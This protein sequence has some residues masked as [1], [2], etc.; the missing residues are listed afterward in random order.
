MSPSAVSLERRAAVVVRAPAR[1]HLGFLDPSGSLGRRYGS[2]GL[3]IDGL[4]TVVQVGAAAR[5]ELSVEAGAEPAEL[6]R[7]AGHLDRLR[8]RSGRHAPLA[9]R[10]L[11]TMP[12]H[13]GFGSGTQLALAVG[14][15]FARWHGLP[16][17]APVLAAWLGRG[18]RSGVG[19][20]G[21]GHGGLLIDGGPGHD[22][23]VAPLL[24]RVDLPASWRVVLVLDPRRQGLSGGAEK[25]AIGALAA[26]PQ[27]DAADICHQVLM[28]V[29]PGAAAADFDA[30]AAGVNRIQRLLGAHFAPAQDGRAYTSAAVARVVEWIGAQPAG[31]AIGQTSWGP[32]GFAIVVSPAAAQALVAGARAAGVVDPALDL[33]IVAA[34]P[35]GA[36]LEDTRP[37]A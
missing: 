19:I 9:L 36:T 2:L 21:F 7:A 33:R 8:E 35:H 31:A 30:F 3:V 29:L 6:E 22:G 14:H 10:L 4:E 13:A 26:L 16:L 20:A 25:Q 12:A 24:A 17:D 23:A 32:T 11:Q 5:D 34:R 37:H 18:A 15:A 27:A 28:R 1:L